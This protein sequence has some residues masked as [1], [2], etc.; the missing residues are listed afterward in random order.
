MKNDHVATL[1]LLHWPL[2]VASWYIDLR[3]MATYSP[4][5]G[6]CTTLSDYF[7]LT[8]RPYETFRPEPDSYIDAVS[9][10]GRGPEG[11]RPNLATDPAS[12]AEGAVRGRGDD[13]R[14]ARAIGASAPVS[15][16]RH[17]FPRCRRLTDASQR[18]GTRRDRPA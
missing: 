17:P 15:G 16:G 4:V 3:R 1:A 5:L 8:D 9:F 10:T 12:P 11:S 14:I 18:R 7:H 13:P 6:R 2:N